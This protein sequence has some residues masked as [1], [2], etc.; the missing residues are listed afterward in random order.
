MKNFLAMA[1]LAS[2]AP[3]PARAQERAA[4]KAER[5]MGERGVVLVKTYTNIGS[6]QGKYNGSLEIDARTFT[7]ADSGSR[8][9]AIGFVVKDGRDSQTSLVDLDDV[10]GLK[11]GL[12][13]LRGFKAP[14]GLGKM[15]EAQFVSSG[16]LELILFNNE[17]GDLGLAVHAGS[18]LKN[19]IFIPA[20]KLEQL[21]EFVALAED[22][23]LGF[24]NAR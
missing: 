10:K 4:T 13:Y 5:F 6:I 3:V 21:T 12:D 11:S 8:E 24:K 19:K 22:K 16:G 15:F 2:L 23:L 9:F 17:G 7:R 1:L 20:A 14:E 18:T